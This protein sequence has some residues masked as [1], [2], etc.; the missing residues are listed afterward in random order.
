MI[1]LDYSATTPVKKE[2][3]D[4][5]VK[6]SMDYPGNANSLHFLGM[7]SK[8]VME[9][10]SELVANYLG[11]RKEEVI[12]TSSATEANNLALKGVLES[13]KNRGKHII[14]T[15][16]EHSSILDT[17][18]YLESIGYDVDYVK[19]QK[20][21]KVKWEDLRS[22]IREDT[23]LI[24]IQHVNSEIGIIQDIDSIGHLLKEHYPKVFFHVDGT[25]S[26][27]KIPVNLEYV[28]LFTC[29]AHKFYGLKGIACL[30]KK[31]NVG[32]IPLIHG[33]KSQ[34][35]YRSGTPMVPLMV[36]FAKALRLALDDSDKKYR[37]VL[38]LN[39]YLREELAKI[40]GVF[41]NSP[42]DA[43]P[44]IL[45]ISI[46]GVKP[47]VMMH[48]LEQEEIY[49]STKT[50]CSKDSGA[51]ISLLA[52]G[53]DEKRASSSLRISLS[54]LTTEQELEEFLKILKQKIEELSFQKNI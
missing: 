20:D 46:P 21:G 7:E 33:G 37:H 35:D 3:I 5:F 25:Q 41:I 53:I 39:K 31:K 10:S 9:R 54:D 29:S 52:L 48:A 26:V 15:K 8:K 23:V 13:Y 11:V 2:V 51:S 4:S 24:S 42:I 38:E 17:C 27:G 12:F 47:E 50:A 43:I 32:L 49:I 44:H 14:T 30:I 18:S 34:T 45:N 36:S 1:Y 28:D 16:L 6:C 22:L 19:V 40:E